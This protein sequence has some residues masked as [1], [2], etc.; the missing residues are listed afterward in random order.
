MTSS[1]KF[2]SF[3]AGLFDRRPSAS[4]IDDFV[5]KKYHSLK[6][7]PYVAEDILSE[8]VELKN[9]LVYLGWIEQDDAVRADTNRRNIRS[10]VYQWVENLSNGKIIDHG[11]IATSA[12]AN[13]DWLDD[14]GEDLNG[15]TS[16]SI[17]ALL[18]FVE[19]KRKKAL[20]AFSRELTS[21]ERIQEGLRISMLLSR[22][23]RRRG[24][25]RFINTA[26]K[27][28]DWYYPILK[29]SRTE[30]Y[31]I[32]YLLALTEQEKSAAEMLK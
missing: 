10:T 17:E 1:I 15:F 3:F 19:V 31:L 28:N 4:E 14:N 7:K 25:L 32:D 21:D 27:M 5:L 16:T 8:L 23:S 11:I 24:D 13:L 29:S 9:N 26:F 22:A 12:G 20:K 30:K 6:H 2:D 18:K